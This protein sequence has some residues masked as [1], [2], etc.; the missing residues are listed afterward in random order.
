MRFTDIIVILIVLLLLLSLLLLFL[1]LS[2]Y[3]IIAL[4]GLLLMLLHAHFL[5][6]AFGQDSLLSKSSRADAFDRFYRLDA[7][8]S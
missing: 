6:L 1:L 5:N 7:Q 3:V 8:Q 2:L 4:K